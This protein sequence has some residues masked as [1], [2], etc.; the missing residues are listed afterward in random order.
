MCVKTR[1]EDTWVRICLTVL[2]FAES[3]YIY[4]KK[5]ITHPQRTFN[6]Y[7]I[8]KNRIWDWQLFHGADQLINKEY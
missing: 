8:Y 1:E 7:V 6:G 2:L 5:C 4:I 3:P